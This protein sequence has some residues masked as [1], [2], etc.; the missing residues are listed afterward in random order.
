MDYFIK[1]NRLRRAETF[2]SHYMEGSFFNHFNCTCDVRF[3]VSVVGCSKFPRARSCGCDVMI[4]ST[5]Q[6]CPVTKPPAPA[7][8]RH[9][10]E[11]LNATR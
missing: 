9:E 11:L 5:N 1:L 6:D 3:H 7:F 10:L 2:N 8:L 4:L